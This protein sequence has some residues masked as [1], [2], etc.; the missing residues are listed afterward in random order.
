MQEDKDD[1]T[2]ERALLNNF[3]L[4]K[5]YFPSINTIYATQ[6]SPET[7]LFYVKS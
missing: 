5:Y 1:L 7:S 2:L 3:C 6:L 4:H